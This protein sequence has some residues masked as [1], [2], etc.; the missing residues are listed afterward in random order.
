MFQA[1]RYAGRLSCCRQPFHISVRAVACWP[2]LSAGG[3][4]SVEKEIEMLRPSKSSMLSD[5][6]RLYV[7]GGTPTKDDMKL[8]KELCLEE[9]IRFRLLSGAKILIHIVPVEIATIKNTQVSVCPT[10]V[11]GLCLPRSDALQ[12]EWQ[13]RQKARCL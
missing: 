12:Q 6:D 7:G 3:K 9:S 4:Q 13:V 2:L 11:I 5:T 1:E 8:V 10:L